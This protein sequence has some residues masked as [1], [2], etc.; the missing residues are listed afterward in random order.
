MLAYFAG[1]VHSNVTIILLRFSFF[2]SF[3]VI[4]NKRG[5]QPG[6][7]LQETDLWKNHS[8]FP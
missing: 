4:L 7:K 8:G 1:F 6:S 3:L 2:F 5:E